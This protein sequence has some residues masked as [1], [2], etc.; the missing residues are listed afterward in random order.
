MEQD[1]LRL[2]TAG[3]GLRP[4]VGDRAAGRA[5]FQHWKLV[6]LFAVYLVGGLC[7]L[8]LS[9]FAKGS[10]TLIWPPSGIALAGLL[11]WGRR[12]WPAVTAGAFVANVLTGVPPA[13]AA[14][15]A[16]GNTLEAVFS[17]RL[18]SRTRN[19]APRFE[20]VRDVLDLLLW[21]GVV[22]TVPSATLGAL[23]LEL[24][25]RL[26][27]E[28]VA[29]TWII[30]WMGDLLSM[31]VFAPLVLAWA[32]PPLPSPSEGP[33]RLEG[34][35]LGAV[36]LVVSAFVFA[37][38]QALHLNDYP[39]EFLVF[40]VILWAGLRF[41]PR[42]V[43]AGTAT[44]LGAAIVATSIGL[45]FEGRLVENLVLL[46]PFIAVLSVT[47]LLL[48]AS[49]AERNRSILALRANEARLEEAVA[50]RE[51][52]LSVAAH[53]LRTP[54]T[55]LSLDLDSLDRALG[56][57]PAPLPSPAR[58]ARRVG[59]AR[60]QLTRLIRLVEELLDVSRIASGRLVLSREEVD[61]AEVVREVVEL[62][63]QAFDQAGCHLTLALSA[64][65][66]V[67]WDRPRMEQVIT[68][69]L[70]NAAK[71]GA[72]RPIELSL[73]ESGAHVE[74]R[75]RDYGIGIGSRDQ[76]R[77][78][79][80]FERAVSPREFGGLGLG[81]FIS[82]EIVKA[83]GGEIRVESELGQGSTFKVQVPLRA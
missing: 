73:G 82:R 9:H 13:V 3:L 6:G 44:F 41:G 35:A 75:V 50:A 48:A 37:G 74:L 57:E 66:R 51:E 20:R 34:W 78:F 19:E 16:A 27:V 30:W 54:L 21:A 42:G 15:I 68:N 77:I 39:I 11:L 38:S 46:Q 43:T 63:R 45:G 40:P 81:L 26:P 4:T 69:L 58:V 79:Q 18:L 72:A 7:G 65:L 52:F 32:Q 70:T 25:G 8:G 71:F 5:G 1:S 17:A 2:E 59:R 28:S 29:V 76:D 64:G 61:P 60:K 22:G 67:Q 14:C 12:L 10:A 49:D 55:A 24:G 36:L 33:R 31:L 80:R 47:G 23:S 56:A 83:H 62:H 53:E